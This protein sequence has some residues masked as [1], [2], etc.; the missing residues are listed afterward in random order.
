[1]DYIAEQW[2]CGQDSQL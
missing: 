2:N 1:M